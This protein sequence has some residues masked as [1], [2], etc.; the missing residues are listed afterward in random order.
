MHNKYLPAHRSRKYY[1]K[2]YFTRD[3]FILFI[4]T[5]EIFQHPFHIDYFYYIIYCNSVTQLYDERR[6]L[7]LFIHIEKQPLFT[8][9]MLTRGILL[10]P[11]DL[12]EY[13]CSAIKIGD[14]HCTVYV[15]IERDICTHIHNIYWIYKHMIS[16]YIPI[17]MSAMTCKNLCTF[18]IL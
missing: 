2:K 6:N 11:L 8:V 15:Y 14:T 7:R 12:S 4:D 3:I 5:L 18:C 16:K 1:L 10:L 13:A 17:I 9:W